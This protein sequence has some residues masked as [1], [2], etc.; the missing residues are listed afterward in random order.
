MDTS[1][2]KL[3]E[4]VMDRE[5]CHVAEHGVAKHRSQLSGWTELQ[6]KKKSYIYFKFLKIIKSLLAIYERNI[7][8]KM[9]MRKE[10][11]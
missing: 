9:F 5:A 3:Q 10:H 4:L 6:K 7:I 11:F 2:S 8:P 1:L